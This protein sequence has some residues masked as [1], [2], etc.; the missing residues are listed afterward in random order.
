MELICHSVGVSFFQASGDRTYVQE[1]DSPQRRMLPVSNSRCL[2]T[3]LL[4]PRRGRPLFMTL[5]R[6]RWSF[7]QGT[8]AVGLGVNGRYLGPA[9]R[10]WKGDD[11]KLICRRTAENNAP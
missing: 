8:R 9:I 1:R 5:Q 3:P 11:V 2:F 10:V 4:S 6:A 7:T